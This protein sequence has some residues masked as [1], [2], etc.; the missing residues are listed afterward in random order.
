M[1][2]GEN[3]PVAF[4]AKSDQKIFRAAMPQMN[5]GVNQIKIKASLWQCVYMS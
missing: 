3:L 1:A 5:Q 4:S 2:V